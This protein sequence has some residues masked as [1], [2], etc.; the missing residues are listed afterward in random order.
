M[1]GWKITLERTWI[2]GRTRKG[3]KKQERKD[4]G[5]MERSLEGIKLDIKGS[6]GMERDE[7][8]LSF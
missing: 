5:F 7:R 1:D 3:E 8:K 4:Q 2:L 6:R